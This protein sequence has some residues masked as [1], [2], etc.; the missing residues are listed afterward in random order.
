MRSQGPFNQS[1]ASHFL[2]LCFTLSLVL[3]LFFPYS[4]IKSVGAQGE[5]SEED[6]AQQ[7]AEA[8]A[9]LVRCYQR[10]VQMDNLG[11]PLP[12]YLDQINLALENLSLAHTAYRLGQYEAAYDYALTAELQGSG[13]ESTVSTEVTR[14]ST[15]LWIQSVFLPVL[16]GGLTV[17]LVFLAWKGGKELE[18]RAKKEYYQARIK[19]VPPASGEAHT[20]EADEYTEERR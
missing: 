14:L 13:L 11:G 8:E 7:I 5:V 9:T 4:S 17:L 6:A 19:L 10:L 1:R 3:L 12:L 18:Q 16:A 2:V 15:L 20:R